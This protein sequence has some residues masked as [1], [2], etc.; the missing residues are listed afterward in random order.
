[1]QC[2]KKQNNKQHSTAYLFQEDSHGT[3]YM[4]LK[5]LGCIIR[6]LGLNLKNKSWFYGQ[7]DHQGKDYRNCNLIKKV[8]YATLWIKDML[9]NKTGKQKTSRKIPNKNQRGWHLNL[10][11]ITLLNCSMSVYFVIIWWY[12]W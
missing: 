3:M 5:L 8:L 9:N 2:I 1:M 11:I 12:W 4:V 7:T 6:K 10:I